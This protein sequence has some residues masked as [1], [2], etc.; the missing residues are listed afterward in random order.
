MSEEVAKILMELLA[1]KSPSGCESE[2]LTYLENFLE[3]LGYGVIRQPIGNII[4]NPK[5]KF[6][7]VTHVDTIEPI[8]EIRRED[9]LIFGTGA[10]DAKGSIASL[11]YFLKKVEDLGLAIA[12]VVDEEREG[13]GAKILAKKYKE[14]MGIIM[15]PTMLRIADKHSG[16]LE[17]EIEVRGKASHASLP[18]YGINAIEKAIEMLTQ[19]KS[20]DLD[21][22]ISV[23]KIRGGSDTYAI[24]E[25]CKVNLDLIIPPKLEVKVIEKNV[26]QVLRNY[27]NYKVVD[28]DEP[29]F[30]DKEVCELIEKAMRQLNLEVKYCTMPSWTDAA[31][32]HKA[33]WKVAVWGPGDLK[34]A[35][36]KNENIS[37][38]EIVKASKVLLKVNDLIK[39]R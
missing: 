18:S 22:E 23:Y 16:T 11:L 20:L 12:F 19:L 8:A 33:N 25:N 35:H 15:E 26:L 31:T 6:W 38:D 9:T 14:R 30:C 2:I 1:I 5:A 29:F 36:T 28:K 39:N 4:I 34:V 27:G 21:A 7:I 3:E 32:L 24:P 13:K 37:I 17:L 10:C